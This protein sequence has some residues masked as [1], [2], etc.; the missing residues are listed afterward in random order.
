MHWLTLNV[1]LLKIHYA[2]KIGLCL[3]N[4]PKKINPNALRALLVDH[5]KTLDKSKILGT[6]A[7]RKVDYSRLITKILFISQYGKLKRHRFCFIDFENEA[8]AAEALRFLSCNGSAF[9]PNYIIAAY[10]IEDARALYIKNKR[11]EQYHSKNPPSALSMMK[12]NK[13]KAYSRG[14]RQ[15]EKRRLQ[16]AQSGNI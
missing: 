15:R 5:F 7:C 8:L 1:S 16:K 9:P 2:I 12:R 10:A 14:A 11:K 4:L 13:R 6:D 3:K